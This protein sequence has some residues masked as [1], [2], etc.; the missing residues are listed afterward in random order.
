VRILCEVPKAYVM[1]IHAESKNGHIEVSEIN[2]EHI[3][4]NTKNAHINITNVK[5]KEILAKTKN[6]HI[7]SE[8]IFAET[9]VYETRNARIEA[10]N[11]KAQLFNLRTSNASVNIDDLDFKQLLIY[12]SNASIKLDSLSK[13]AEPA[14][15]EIEAHTSN[16][17][18]KAKLPYDVGITLQATT[19]NGKIRSDINDM[20]Y[21]TQTDNYIKGECNLYQQSPNRLKVNLSTS[22]GSVK[23]KHV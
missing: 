2:A 3:S 5:C 8:N 13:F 20:E 16:A 14:E 11:S 9:A 22:N 7:Y 15:R 4:L 10:E 19:T 18:I 23:I 1:R 12:T 21:E 17:S 6:A